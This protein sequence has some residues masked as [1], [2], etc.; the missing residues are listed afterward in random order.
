MAISVIAFPACCAF[1]ILQ[2]LPLQTMITSY[3]NT[4]EQLLVLLNAEKK[5][6]RDFF[7]TPHYTDFNHSNMV[8]T[9]NQY[10]V[11]QGLGQI[12]K[13]E[14]YRLVDVK[15]NYNTSL[16]VYTYIRVS[17]QFTNEDMSEHFAAAA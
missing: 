9:L 10:Q 11:K 16:L 3:G 14:G 13:D 15:R 2:N 4:K 17:N 1:H 7:L 5:K 12:L 6:V 8:A